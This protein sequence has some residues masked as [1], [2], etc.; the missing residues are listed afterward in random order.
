LA[1]RFAAKEAVLKAM[2]TGWAEGIAW[3]EIEVAA[4][5]SG[6]PELRLSGKA[7]ELAAKQGISSW[8]ISISHTEG[9]AMASVIAVGE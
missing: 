5:A 1:G 4:R 3:T 6:Q 2:G 8:Q 9:Q 7:A